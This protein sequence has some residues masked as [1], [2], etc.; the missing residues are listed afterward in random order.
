MAKLTFVVPP[1]TTTNRTTPVVVSVTGG[2]PGTMMTI[3]LKQISENQKIIKND[4]TARTDE[5]GQTQCI[6]SI[7][8]AETGKISLVATATDSEFSFFEPAAIF[9]TVKE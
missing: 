8:F 9:I 5:N 1:A 4:Q 2:A 3:S 7:D 6:F